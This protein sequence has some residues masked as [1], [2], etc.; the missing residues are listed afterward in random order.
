[1]FAEFFVGSD[2]FPMGGRNVQFSTLVYN[3]ASARFENPRS[4]TPSENPVCRSVKITQGIPA[5]VIVNTLNN[6]MWYHHHC[7]CRS[8]SL[9]LFEAR[10]KKKGSTF[11]H[12][13]SYLLLRL[14][15]KAPSLKAVYTLPEQDEANI[16]CLE[17]TMNARRILSYTDLIPDERNAFKK[18]VGE[19]R[20]MVVDVT[21]DISELPGWRFSQLEPEEKKNTVILSGKSSAVAIQRIRRIRK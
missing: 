17:L 11:G 2:S 16:H 9:W 12:D 7:E 20:D 6:Q 14:S 5:S 15:A 3:P 19:T 8:G 4:L 18:F 1:M 21:Q 10:I 13:T